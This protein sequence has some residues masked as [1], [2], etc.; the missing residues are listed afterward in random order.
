MVSTRNTSR[1]HVNPPRMQD[2]Q[3]DVDSR[4]PAGTPEDIQANTDEMEAF[5]LT[6]QRLLRELKQL[7]RQLQRPQEARQAQEGLN[8]LTQGEQEQLDPPRGAD[9]EGETIQTRKRDPY[10]PPGENCNEVRHGRDNR[11]N[12]PIPILDQQEKG[13]RSWEQR[14]RGIQQELTI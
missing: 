6:N 10:K 7:T 5:H 12:G 3:G 4:S 2:Q 11:S 13:E 9:G 8:P 14:F 1:S